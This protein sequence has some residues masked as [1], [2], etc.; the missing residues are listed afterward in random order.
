MSSATPDKTEQL[1]RRELALAMNGNS[2]QQREQFGLSNTAWATLG[3]RN[4][5]NDHVSSSSVIAAEVKKLVH[6]SL[7]SPVRVTT[8]RTPLSRRSQVPKQVE[9]MMDRH[10][11][12]QG[13]RSESTSAAFTTYT[14]STEVLTVSSSGTVLRLPS[15]PRPSSNNSVDDVT[16]S[17]P[18]AR[19][20]GSSEPVRG[21]SQQQYLLGMHLVDQDPNSPFALKAAWTR[22]C[23]RATADFSEHELCLVSCDTLRLLMSEYGIV[24]PEE[25]AQIEAHWALIQVEMNLDP[26]PQAPPTPPPHEHVGQSPQ[27]S[28]PPPYTSTPQSGQKPFS[29]SHRPFSK[30]PQPRPSPH[31][32]SAS[33]ATSRVES[34]ERS[35]SA[36]RDMNLRTG[37]ARP[38]LSKRHLILV[39][40][41]SP[42]VSDPNSCVYR[43]ES[44]S[45]SARGSSSSTQRH[46]DH[47]L[48][49]FPVRGCPPPLPSSVRCNIEPQHRASPEGIRT[50]Y[51]ERR[52]ISRSVSYDGAV[53]GHPLRV[54]PQTAKRV[55]YDTAGSNGLPLFSNAT[56]ATSESSPRSIRRFSSNKNVS[57]VRPF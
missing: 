31:G 34:K 23:N 40:A 13:K 30:S 57:S 27:Q 6:L 1:L 52:E 17:D 42:V 21:P 10:G 14:T 49:A 4:N 7:H 43:S 28:P 51:R 26:S 46:E 55:F 9:E 53:V 22:F 29:P 18:P 47:L 19:A 8:S 44:K 35:S 50:E 41:S 25:V 16:I 12:A 39:S 24:A 37:P 2:Q 15:A 38:H 48:G 5:S 20:D 33:A 32:N 56:A 11:D 54:S 3:L 45:K 36:G